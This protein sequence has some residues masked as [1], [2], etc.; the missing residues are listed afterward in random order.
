MPTTTANR[1]DTL[2]IRLP[3]VTKQELRRAAQ[4]R[5]PRVSMSF[6]AEEFILRGLKNGPA[7]TNDAH[8]VPS[9]VGDTREGTNT[10]Q[11]S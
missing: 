6:L 5:A 4:R 7:T 11:A 9:S 2:A 3:K 10:G 8:P 1:T